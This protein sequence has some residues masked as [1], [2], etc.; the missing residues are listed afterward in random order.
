V[1]ALVDVHREDRGASEEDVTTRPDVLR[2]GR[3]LIRLAELEFYGKLT[4][5]F[6]NGRIVDLRTEQVMKIDELG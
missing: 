2:I 4:V 3:F 6:Q 1:L 5:S